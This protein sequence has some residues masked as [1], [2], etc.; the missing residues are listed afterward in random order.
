MNNENLNPIKISGD[1]S[2]SKPMTKK[3]WEIFFEN[4]KEVAEIIKRTEEIEEKNA[5]R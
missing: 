4:A 2:E 5:K 3:D 1:L